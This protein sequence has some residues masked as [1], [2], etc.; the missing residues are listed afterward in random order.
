[1][2]T[3]PDEEKKPAAGGKENDAL[4]EKVPGTATGDT[5]EANAPADPPSEASS[6]AGETSVG[7]AQD[8]G[9]EVVGDKAAEQ[10]PQAGSL[11]SE[12]PLK[13][14]W[15]TY[16]IIIAAFL[17]IW[18]AIWFGLILPVRADPPEPEFDV[19]FEQ[20]PAPEQ[21]EE[22]PPEL[23]DQLPSET[24]DDATERDDEETRPTEEE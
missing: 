6:A 24:D 17:G 8:S 10:P 9:S 13:P 14:L 21:D 5:S 16:G 7:S 20:R 2:T 12:G 15:A 1:M 3:T 23:E 22:V 19:R 11:P 18:V 4:G